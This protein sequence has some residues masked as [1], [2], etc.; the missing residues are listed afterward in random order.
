MPA[1]PYTTGIHGP[2]PTLQDW[3]Y[4]YVGTGL[5]ET[6]TAELV[7]AARN[8]R[9]MD[10]E[11]RSTAELLL[12]MAFNS[13]FKPLWGEDA[14]YE[15]ELEIGDVWYRRTRP[16]KA[17]FTAEA[18]SAWPGAADFFK[19][20]ITKPVNS[21]HRPWT[22]RIVYLG[23]QRFEPRSARFSARMTATRL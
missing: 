19:F 23:P 7:R 18:P 1:N 2:A 13:V 20:E 15:H 4:E 21:L 10:C 17:Y 22:V 11:Q 14:W 3:R 8:W 9:S 5:D 16:L 12:N 6:D